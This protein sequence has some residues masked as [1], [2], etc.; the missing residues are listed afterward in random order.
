MGD[1][2]CYTE[3][4]DRH[5]IYIDASL[6]ISQFML[7][8]QTLGLSTCA[9]NWPDVE[10]RERELQKAIGLKKY[11]RAVMFISVGYADSQGKVP[12]SQ[13][14]GTNVLMREMMER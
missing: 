4:R 1:L 7:A 13:K 8:L 2:S 5:L 9:I 10:E 3:E 11:E 12:Y 6:A 14:K